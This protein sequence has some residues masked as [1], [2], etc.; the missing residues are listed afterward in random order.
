M[1]IGFAK[2]W[3][4]AMDSPNCDF[5]MVQAHQFPPGSGKRE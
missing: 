5:I 1:R 3:S 2:T 4:G